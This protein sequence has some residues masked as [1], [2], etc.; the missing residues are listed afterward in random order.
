MNEK[1]MVLMV[2]ATP[3]K[4]NDEKG[5]HRE[6]TSFKVHLAYFKDGAEMPY[7]VESCKASEQEAR[8]AFQ[9]V[10]GMFCGTA[11]FDKYGRFCGIAEDG[12]IGMG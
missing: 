7:A 11:I 2:S 10:G 3:Y 1:I 9:H 5:V 8:K 4:F 6:G 12:A